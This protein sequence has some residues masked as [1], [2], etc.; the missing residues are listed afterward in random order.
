MASPYLYSSP[1][2]ADSTPGPLTPGTPFG[3]R[4]SS[5]EAQITIKL[6]DDQAADAEGEQY[7]E[8]GPEGKAQHT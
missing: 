6:P 1:Y 4:P 3:M 2:S 5:G 7:Q 8:M